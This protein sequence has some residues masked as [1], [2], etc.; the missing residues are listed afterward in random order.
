MVWTIVIVLGVVILGF[1]A[2]MY[3]RN[4]PHAGTR[5]RTQKV[6]DMAFEKLERRF[7]DEQKQRDETP[8]T[9]E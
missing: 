3:V 7:Q 9:H 5:T 1:Y 2:V 8:P 6:D 4:R